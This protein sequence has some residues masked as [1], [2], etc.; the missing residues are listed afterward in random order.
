[1][2][3]LLRRI[4]WDGCLLKHYERLDYLLALP[5]LPIGPSLGIWVVGAFVEGGGGCFGM[6]C[7][8]GGCPKYQEDHRLA[9]RNDGP[10]SGLAF[11]SNDLLRDCL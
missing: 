1:M 10:V 9:N 7:G 2:V 8:D 5:G 3:G 4:R 11:L 6:G